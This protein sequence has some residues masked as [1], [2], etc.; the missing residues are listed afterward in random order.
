MPAQL[1]DIDVIEHDGRI[2]LFH[3]VL[4]NHDLVAHAVSD[5]GLTWSPL[6]PAMCTGKPGDCDDDMIWTMQVVRRPDG[7]GFHMYYTGCSTAEHGQHQRVALATST[8]LIHW[9]RHPANPVLV[10]AP[11]HYNDQLGLVGFVSFRDP[12][13]F[14][15]DGTWH[16]LVTARTTQGGRFTRGCVAHA[17]SADGL[18]WQLQPPLYAPQ[19]MEDCEVPAVIRLGSRYYLHLHDFAGNGLYRIADSLAGPWHAPLRDQLLPPNNLVHRF[20]TWRGRLLMYHWLRG[21]VDWQRRAAGSGVSALAPPKEVLALPNGELVLH[22]FAGW[23][24]RH[25]G[26]PVTLDLNAMARQGSSP[27]DPWQTQ[28]HTLQ[29]NTFG[30]AVALAPQAFDH[31][32]FQT[33]LNLHHG[34]AAGVVLRTDPGLEACTYVRLDFAH[35]Q[36]ELHRHRVFD[37][38]LHRYKLTKPTLLQAM[39]ARLTPGQDL[40]LRVLACREY[41]EVCLNDVVY[42]SANTY[43]AQRGQIGL[44]VEDAQAEFSDATV[45]GLRAV[46]A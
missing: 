27:G 41:I 28:A 20:C 8:D 39:P 16:M 42:L 11:P 33:T 15:E 26:D 21:P 36:I 38:S 32:I 37:S 23:S 1:G 31:F 7:R 3:L 9:T 24:D 44:M 25:A 46:D 12:F 19:H 2:H 10:A 14:I 13:V 30:R 6:P 17:T 40:R 5:D 35:G 34:R 4:P 29:V 45:Q 18:R 22:S 43:H